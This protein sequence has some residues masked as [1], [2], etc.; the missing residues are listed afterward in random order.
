MADTTCCTLI[1]TSREVEIQLHTG[2][3]V[4]KYTGNNKF[5]LTLH[6]RL[7][8]LAGDLQVWAPGLEPSYK[9]DLW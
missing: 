5:L 7:I 4:D 1:N 3:N 9:Q 2:Y 8:H 6:G